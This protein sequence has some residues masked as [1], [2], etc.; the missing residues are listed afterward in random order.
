MQGRLKFVFLTETPPADAAHFEREIA[1]GCQELLEA[2]RARVDVGLVASVGELVSI[3]GGAD[4]LRVEAHLSL[5]HAALWR[6]VDAVGRLAVA[7]WA[8]RTAA[9]VGFRTGVLLQDRCFFDVG[10]L[11][12]ADLRVRARDV[13]YGNFLQPDQFLCHYAVDRR[14][15]YF[16][17][18][19]MMR[20]F[21]NDDRMP[22]DGE[23]TV[24][25]DFEHDRRKLTVCF[26][27]LAADARTGG[28][29]Q[30][31]AKLDVAY[32]TIRRI[33]VDFSAGEGACVYLHVR[34]APLVSTVKFARRNAQ[35]AEV[36]VER[37]ELQTHLGDR[38]VHW[39]PM[40]LR[41]AHY[42]EDVRAISQAP[43]LKLDLR[44]EEKELLAHI[45]GRLTAVTR[46]PVELRA[47]RDVVVPARPVALVSRNP[48]SYADVKRIGGDGP[49]VDARPGDDV[50]FKYAFNPMCDDKWTPRL[51]HNGRRDFAL[52][53]LF[54]ALMSQGAHVNDQ[55]LVRPGDCRAL[56]EK[57]VAVYEPNRR[58]CLE[59]LERLLHLAA[60]R[61]DLPPLHALF[62]VA[63]QE[64][65][66]ALQAEDEEEGRQRAGYVRLRKVT[67]TPSRRVFDAPELIMGNRV[68]RADEQNF[69]TERFLRVSF[70]DENFGRIQPNIGA[71]FI[72]VFVMETLKN[73]VRV[74][75]RRFNYL[76]SSN[77][78]MRDQGCYLIEAE[79]TEIAAFRRKLGAFSIDSVPKLMARFGQ[80]FTQSFALGEEMPRERYTN[81]PD[82]IG[83]RDSNGEPYTFSDGAGCMSTAFAKEVAA[84]MQL[85]DCLPSC[86]QTRFRGFKGVHAMNPALDAVAAYARRHG[87]SEATVRASERFLHV[88]VWFRES[89]EKFVTPQEGHRFEVVKVS[90]PSAVCLNRPFINIL[91]QVAEKHGPRAHA[92]MCDRVHE[93]LDQ[94]LRR[95]AHS[96]TNEPAARARLGEFPRVVMFEALPT[97]N[98][99]KEPFFRS[100][101]RVAA[102]STLKK[103]RSKLQIAVPAHLGRS[104]LGVVDE[105]GLLGYGE[106][107]VQYTSNVQN[108]RP[109]PHA[110]RC[111]LA[112]P[113]LV[114]KNPMLVGG[115]VRMFEAVNLPALHHLNDVIVFPRAGPRPHPDEMAGSDLDGDE[116]CVVWDRG[117]FLARN[118][119]PYDYTCSQKP[120]PNPVNEDQLRDQMAAFFLD[121]ISHDSLG[122]LA[123]AFLVNADLY[124]IESEVCAKVAR[125]HMAAV[126]FPK[127]GIPA[128][129]LVK[130]KQGDRKPDYMEQLFKPTYVSPRLNGQLFRRVKEIDD[131]LEISVEDELNVAPPLD[132]AFDLGEIEPEIMERARRAFGRYKAAMENLLQRFGIA[133]EAEVFSQC[134]SAIRRRINDKDEDDMSFFNTLR[135]IEDELERIFAHHRR[136]FM[137]AFG[138][139]FEQLTEN[140]NRRVQHQ[141]ESRRVLRYA[142]RYATPALEQL[143]VAYYRVA[144]TQGN[145]K[146][147]S[148]GWLAADV[149][150][151]VLAAA[152]KPAVGARSAYSFDPTG[153][154]LSERIAAFRR[155]RRDDFNEFCRRVQ[156]DALEPLL[157]AKGRVLVRRLCRRHAGLPELLFF[158]A[159]WTER[160]G[161]WGAEAAYKTVLLFVLFGL[162]ALPETTEAPFLEDEKLEE[163]KRQASVDLQ[164]Q[165]GGCGQK[166]LLFLEFLAGRAFSRLPAVSFERLGGEPTALDAADVQ[167][168]HKAALVSYFQVCL[169][170][171]LGVLPGPSAHQ[172]AVGSALS[173]VD[174]ESFICEVPE[175][176]REFV[177]SAAVREAL[178]RRTG[179]RDVFLR[180]L[181]FR[182]R[183]AV[184]Q[185]MVTLSGSVPAAN[186]LRA[187][188]TP[189]LD[190]EQLGRDFT[191]R[192]LA[193]HLSLQVLNNIRRA[194]DLPEQAAVQEFNEDMLV[195]FGV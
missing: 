94:Q 114:T 126:D 81:M 115:D 64:A 77:S 104:M 60:E 2:L 189:R 186:A 165:T 41:R 32:G 6:L 127:T 58:L 103:L 76:G 29:T 52:E 65:T 55:F 5:E 110:P 190:F 38:Y 93:L 105:S 68:L 178:V 42:A 173:A 176:E 101:L 73:G 107:F 92:D 159:R 8:G 71:K 84:A 118:E 162:K 120:V 180:A 54:D 24:F 167:R 116:Y 100:L 51:R 69:P 138:G 177:L 98:L 19:T 10:R 83:G 66:R 188:L 59:A 136:E 79:D 27:I 12:G 130:H 160:Q 4:G 20:H 48:T 129:K 28:H 23:Q 13:F 157:A 134:Y 142:I 18:A 14:A 80:C 97:M 137:E 166:F 45:L 161:E 140:P 155:A 78:Q 124:G 75:G 133:T 11:S 163:D 113:V 141:K 192:E 175:R 3:A 171:N 62:D 191:E 128:E 39:I 108:K 193:A 49:V 44:G 182:A 1:A 184:V 26:P 67:I 164:Q 139:T 119:P 151:R 153:D 86:F 144:Y 109:G 183:H 56:M 82:F 50:R 85:G 168:L 96:L 121:Y 152:P 61:E 143:A 174:G 21:Y 106:V 70:R 72:E 53:Y 7:H 149:R 34:S 99:T 22:A 37:G 31:V 135:V 102:R 89:Q 125:K 25:V 154:D 40:P 156:K 132:P 194:M 146:F 185:V 36:R 33:F 148:F 90:G 145:Q 117:L 123:T 30:A 170:G 195:D 57:V 172:P 87:L 47:V 187:V 46:K 158:A 122:K 91:D 147:L 17:T 88:D 181:P 15:A 43:Y 169:V 179:C 74:A 131:V 112:G 95:V 16:G 150:Q 111:V 35:G 9:G 63:R